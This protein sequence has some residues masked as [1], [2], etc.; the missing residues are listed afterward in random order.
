MLAGQHVTF[1]WQ[2]VLLFI[3]I[4]FFSFSTFPCLRML[5]DYDTLGEHDFGRWLR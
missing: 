3:Y 1:G 4:F 2:G 5:L